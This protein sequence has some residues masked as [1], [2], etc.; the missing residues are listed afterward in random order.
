[1]TNPC[2]FDNYPDEDPDGPDEE[3]DRPEEEPEGPD[4]EPE[5]REEDAEPSD[6]LAAV[7]ADSQPSHLT[8]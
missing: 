3:P 7:F 8:P 5:R 6:P 4:E 2:A 1:M